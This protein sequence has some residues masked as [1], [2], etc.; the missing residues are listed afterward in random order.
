MKNRIMYGYRCEYWEGTVMPW[1]VKR[2]SFKSKNG[3][4]ILENVTIGVSFFM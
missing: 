2:E 3:F 4:I 1:A